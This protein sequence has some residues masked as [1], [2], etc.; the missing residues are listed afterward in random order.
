MKPDEV[1]VESVTLSVQPIQAAHHAY[2]DANHESFLEL[3]PF[4]FDKVTISCLATG[5]K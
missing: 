2:Q 3:M 1:G 5:Q 4:C